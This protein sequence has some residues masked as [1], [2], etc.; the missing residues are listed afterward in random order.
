MKNKDYAILL[1][2]LF[3]PFGFLYTY[4]ASKGMFWGSLLLYGGVSF[5]ITFISF[6]WLWVLLY[7][8]FH[9]IGVWR[10]FITQSESFYKN[11]PYEDYN[12]QDII[13]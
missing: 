4:Q 9:V 3:I 6:S 8:I 2:A 5:M 12:L 11:Y 7:I 1:G 13:S 10:F